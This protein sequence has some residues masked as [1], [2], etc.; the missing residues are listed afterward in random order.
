[1]ATAGAKTTALE[2][3]A[4]AAAATAIATMIAT[5]VGAET[6]TLPA[7]ATATVMTAMA[8][9]VA[10]VEAEATA[11]A[12]RDRLAAHHQSAATPATLHPHVIRQRVAMRTAVVATIRR[13]KEVGSLA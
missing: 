5:E 8:A 10:V 3:T 13:T 6:T 11:G 4:A 12:T 9:S 1:V 2:A 7:A